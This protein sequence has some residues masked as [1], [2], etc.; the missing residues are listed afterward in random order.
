[1]TLPLP[2]LDKLRYDQLVDEARDLLPY[3][4]PE[5]TD[6]N[7]HDPGITLLELF[8]WITEANSYRLDRVPTQSER[9]FLRLV[10]FHIRQAQVARTVLTFAANSAT[11]LPA[12]VQVG[13]AD[14]KARF[15]T[16]TPFDVVASSVVTLMSATETGWAQHNTS[17]PGFQPFGARPAVGDAFY[18]GLDRALSPAARRVRLFALSDDPSL[19]EQAWLALHAEH[20]RA[21]RDASAGCR[22]SQT[23]RPTFWEHHGVRV[24]WEYF[25]GSLW[26]ALPGLRDA[27]RALSLSGPLRF[28]APADMQAGG[29]PEHDSLWFIRC[30]MVC[31]EFDCAPQLRAVLLNAVMARHAADNPPH[32]LGVSNGQAQQ[33]FDVSDEPIVP[34]STQI[35]LTL[36]DAT[37]STWQEHPDF[38]R[39]GGLARHYVI[40]PE[41][42]Q[43]VFGN[44]RTGRVPEAGASLSISW[45]TGGGPSGNLPAQALVSPVSPGLSLAVS[46][47]F[48]AWGGADAETLGAAKAR[49]VRSIEHARCAVTL[50]DFETV[51]LQVPG[52]PVARAHAVAEF[53]PQLPH[54]PA[55]GCITVVVLTPCVR[56][57]PDPTPALC[58]AVGRFIDARRPVATEVHVT[59]PDWTKVTVK[60]RLRTRDGVN[61]AGLR[62]EARRRIDAFFDP[63]IGGPDSQGWP[64]GRPVYR[65]EVLALLDALPG[66]VAVEGLVLIHDDRTDDFCNNLALCPHG[67]V[68]SGAHEFS[69][70]PETTR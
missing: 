7:A 34:C 40:D 6:H 18:I 3:L 37:Q 15:Q 35:T 51:A 28:H 30:R 23:C 36:P 50:Q 25:N 54:L 39:S 2:Q 32:S 55:A 63:L 26:Q 68:L 59:G 70:L 11:S 16:G 41:R 49:A 52:A 61:A 45:Q 67:L 47:P 17:G 56:K 14:R 29:V 53:H 69:V 60:V 62:N 8:A 31:G 38:D 27:T 19:D 10:G 1:M 4:A 44:G 57:H 24:A 46:Q 33:R 65:S 5:W 42:G 48:S 58:R 21:R 13:T 20:R 22:R 9:A 12:R 43:A 64:F 66:V